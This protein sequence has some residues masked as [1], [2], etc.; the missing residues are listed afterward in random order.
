MPPKGAIV[1]ETEFKSRQVI[2]ERKLI[3]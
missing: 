1:G 3:R 2:V